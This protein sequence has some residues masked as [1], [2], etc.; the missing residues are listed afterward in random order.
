MHDDRSID[1][2]LEQL[3]A[4]PV[5]DLTVDGSAVGGLLAAAFGREITGDEERCAHCGTS[6]VIATMR[7]YAR[8]PGVVIRC[9]ACTDVVLRIVETP[10]GLRID[11]SGATHLR[12]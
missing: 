6:S 3:R 4:D 12:G 11:A 8:G 1:E 10:T 9:P 7:V 5:L 2:R